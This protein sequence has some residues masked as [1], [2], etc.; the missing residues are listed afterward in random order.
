M[1]QIRALS[2]NV[3]IMFII[4]FFQRLTNAMFY[5]FLAIFLSNYFSIKHTGLILL[6]VSLFSMISTLLGG[7]YTNIVGKRRILMLAELLKLMSI[8]ILLITTNMYQTFAWLIVLVL[9]VNNFSIGLSSPVNQTIM[10][11]Y[12]T[13]E[14]RRFVYTLNY[15]IFNVSI[16]CG[17]ILG[18]TIIET[19]K[20]IVFSC[21]IVSSLMTITLSGFLDL[22]ENNDVAS[23]YKSDNESR[24]LKEIFLGYS[25]V[26]KDNTF[27]KFVIAGLL[28]I[29]LE[30]QFT[31]YI[32]IHLRNT[33]DPQI[34]GEISINGVQI[35]G[36][37]RVINTIIIVL[38]S[39]IILKIFKN[40]SNNSLLI[41]GMI[42]F[43]IGITSLVF[44]TYIWLLVLGTILFSIGEI[45]YGPASQVLLSKLVEGKNVSRYMAVEDLVVKGA[46]LLGSLGILIGAVFQKSII[47]I[48]FLLL[49]VISMYLY[50]NI[51]HKIGP[52]DVNK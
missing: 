30:L 16:G 31:N 32:S 49:G 48:F 37:L 44:K 25:S 17:T 24:A 51:F 23:S 9:V 6:C 12:S 26:L 38:C 7:H 47:I 10:I 18:A 15:W 4:T 11:E 5:P 39:T 52:I 33:F 21:L 3:K 40:V 8:S 42:L 27:I 13:D 28:F 45:M 19:H 41:Y 20:L 35:L 43:T 50:K 2:R 14:N 22:K 29:G 36:I 1:K 34:I 46:T